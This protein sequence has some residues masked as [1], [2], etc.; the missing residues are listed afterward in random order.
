MLELLS[1]WLA[2]LNNEMDS[3]WCYAGLIQTSVTVCTPTDTDMDRNRLSQGMDCDHG[4]KF[5]RSP[6]E[7]RRRFGIAVLPSFDSFGRS[8]ECINNLRISKVKLEVVRLEL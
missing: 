3:F 2:E 5:L 4:A 6:R 8:K 7:T 1:P